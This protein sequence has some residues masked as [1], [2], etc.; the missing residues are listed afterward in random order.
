MQ[1]ILACV[2]M[3]AVSLPVSYLLA[4]GC[5]DGMFRILDSEKRD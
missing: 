2:L 4:R 3:A 5:L 1:N